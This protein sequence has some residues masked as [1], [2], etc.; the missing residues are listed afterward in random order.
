MDDLAVCSAGIEVIIFA[1]NG[2]EIPGWLTNIPPYLTHLNWHWCTAPQGR[3]LQLNQGAKLAAARYSLFVH[4]DLRLT[5]KN[6]VALQKA[7]GQLYYFDLS[8]VNKSS[9]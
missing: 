4:A 3:A 7:T 8:F 1:I 6:I 2:A 9:R 5:Q